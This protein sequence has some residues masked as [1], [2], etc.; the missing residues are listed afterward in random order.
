MSASRLATARD[1][2]VAS[3]FSVPSP[4]TEDSP[5]E[6][7]AE[8]A[9]ASDVNE[10]TDPTVHSPAEEAP[11][12]GAPNG[13]SAVPTKS[14]RQVRAPDAEFVPIQRV[15]DC[16]VKKV[17]VEVPKEMKDWIAAEARERGVSKNAIMSFGLLYYM[18]RIA[19]TPAPENIED[20]RQTIM[21]RGGR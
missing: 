7:Y 2:S 13:S 12:P 4:V 18:L 21:S 11:Q 16:I 19:E 9:E 1:E 10:R 17:T 20:V 5:D 15:K 6:Q 3:Q 8:H 14:K